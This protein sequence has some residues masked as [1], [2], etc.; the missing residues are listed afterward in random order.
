MSTEKKRGHNWRVDEVLL[1]EEVKLREG[2]LFGSFMGNGGIK[3]NT[4]KKE[5]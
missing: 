1:I 3:G 5:K 4:L 2:T